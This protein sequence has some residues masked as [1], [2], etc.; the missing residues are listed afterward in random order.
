MDRVKGLLA[1]LPHRSI[2]LLYSEQLY[3]HPVTR[4]QTPG[5]RPQTSV[6]WDEGKLFSVAARTLGAR[7]SVIHYKGTIPDLGELV[8]DAAMLDVLAGLRLLEED[9]AQGDVS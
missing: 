2:S 7:P 9:R 3:A 8:S 5:A 6:E 4:L 1:Q